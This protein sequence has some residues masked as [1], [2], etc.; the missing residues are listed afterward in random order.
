MNKRTI[1]TEWEKRAAD[2]LQQSGMKIIARNFRSRQGEIDLIGY[3]DGYLVFT[4]VKYRS[5]QEAGYALQAVDMHKRRQ[6]CKVADYYRYLHHI[7]DQTPIRYDV[8][9]FQKEE[10]CWVQNAFSHIYTRNY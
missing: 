5:G 10:I 8:V 4:E 7:S 6:I 2:F 3:H 1:G 9:A